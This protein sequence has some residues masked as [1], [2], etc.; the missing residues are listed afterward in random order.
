MGV[1]RKRIPVPVMEIIANHVG[2]KVKSNEEIG[3]RSFR[4]FQV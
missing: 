4:F 3:S 1:I 2:R